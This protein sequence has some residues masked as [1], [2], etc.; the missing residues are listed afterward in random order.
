MRK[1]LHRLE[2]TYRQIDKKTDWL[3]DRQ[4][5]RYTER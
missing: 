4:R 1:R 2:K 5:E 3:I